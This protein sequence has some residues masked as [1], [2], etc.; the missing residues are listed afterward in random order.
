MHF[1]FQV[2]QFNRL[3]VSKAFGIILLPYNLHQ[4]LKQL[5]LA[6]KAVM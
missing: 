4:Q 2:I 6:Y 1:F 3:F 5:T